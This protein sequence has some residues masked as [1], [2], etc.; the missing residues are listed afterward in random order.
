MTHVEIQKWCLDVST[1][2]ASSVIFSTYLARYMQMVDHQ[3]SNERNPQL[4]LTLAPGGLLEGSMHLHAES[5]LIYVVYNTILS[6]RR[7]EPTLH[8]RLTTAPSSSTSLN[9]RKVALLSMDAYWISLTKGS[10]PSTLQT[11]CDNSEA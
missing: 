11:V 7:T 10:L 3:P 9:G 2:G 1:A 5:N 4:Y 8:A 6:M